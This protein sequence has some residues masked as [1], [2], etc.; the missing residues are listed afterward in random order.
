MLYINYFIKIK[1]NGNKI[2]SLNN[3]QILK[4]LKYI[5]KLGTLDTNN[6]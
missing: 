3:L 6:L 4:I 1:T 2:S 5:S